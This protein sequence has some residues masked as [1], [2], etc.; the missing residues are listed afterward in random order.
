MVRRIGVIGDVHSEGDALGVALAFLSA[1]PYLDAL[2]CTG[3]LSARE[4]A[5]DTAR[6]CYLLKTADALTVRGNHDRW[7]LENAPVR[8]AALGRSSANADDVRASAFIAS[9]PPIRE[10]DTPHGPLLLCHG[11]RD[12]DMAGIYPGDDDA[13]AAAGLW[14]HE[15]TRERVRFV[16]N[17]HTHRRMVRTLEGVTIINAGTLLWNN[18]PCFLV[19]DFDALTVQFY[20]IAPLNNAVTVGEKVALA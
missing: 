16:V 10:F 1:L 8:A 15:L 5:G 18:D 4:G 7:Y 2:L 9:L 3:D 14:R 6:V 11:L 20:D 19:A 13:Q 12:N 17:G